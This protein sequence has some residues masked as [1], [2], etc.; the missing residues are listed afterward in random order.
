M[1]CYFDKNN[2]ILKLTLSYLACVAGTRRSCDEHFAGAVQI[3]DFSRHTC[4]FF[5]R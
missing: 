2:T 4:E 3:G 5:E 1:I